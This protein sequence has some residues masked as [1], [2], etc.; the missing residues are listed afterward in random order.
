MRERGGVKGRMRVRQLEGMEG[1]KKESERRGTEAGGE[2][3]RW[4][5]HLKKLKREN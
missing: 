2:G 4:K 3:E 1:L 5:Y